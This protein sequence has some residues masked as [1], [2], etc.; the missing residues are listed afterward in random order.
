M[1]RA[2][3]VGQPARH[4]L[5]QRHGQ[6]LAPKCRRA[7]LVPKGETPALVLMARVLLVT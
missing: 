7:S 1:R 4:T 2:G 5:V 6:G 3:D